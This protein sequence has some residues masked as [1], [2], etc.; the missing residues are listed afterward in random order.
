MEIALIKVNLC[1]PQT[2]EKEPL[3]LLIQQS[4]NNC[5]Y[6]FQANDDLEKFNHVKHF[7]QRNYIASRF[8]ETNYPTRYQ[9]FM[10]SFILDNTS[11]SILVM[12]NVNAF[13]MCLL[14]TI[15]LIIANSKIKN[16]FLLAISFTV[17]PQGLF[18]ASSINPSSWSYIGC[19]FSWAF[20]WIIVS[21]DQ[22]FTVSNYVAFAGWVLA[23]LLA[24]SSRWDSPLW[25]IFTNLTV[26][27]LH[28]LTKKNSLK[29]TAIF[30]GA[31]LVSVIAY[32]LLGP[33]VLEGIYPSLTS[34]FFKPWNLVMAI[35][36]GAKLT[37]ATP[38]RILGLEDFGWSQIQ[39][40]NEVFFGG[41]LFLVLVISF[42]I[43]FKEI[44]VK[45]FFLSFLVLFWMVCTTQVAKHPTWMYPFYLPRTGWSNDLFHSRY[46]LPVFPFFVGVAALISPKRE[47]LVENARFK[48]ALIVILTFTHAISL[49][50]VGQIFRENPSWYWPN[51]P[52]NIDL[53]FISGSISFFVFVLTITI[54]LGSVQ[55]ASSLF[56][57]SLSIARRHFFSA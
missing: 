47:K 10:N 26:L 20:L 19:T 30:S 14:F 37:L 17:V 46:F 49:Q 4:K 2:T 32:R 53:V 52:I 11:L 51:F 45:L 3:P 31:T 25:L 28:F 50:S 57:N 54:I 1:T 9:K 48:N 34:E 43:T 55:A 15:L 44:R 24:I 16:S 23:S 6:E 39:P 22:K 7:E 29:I 21:A 42:L 56:P 13:L 36:G 33:L 12:R 41:V 27:S 18:I 38:V 8:N 40:P 35:G 5:R